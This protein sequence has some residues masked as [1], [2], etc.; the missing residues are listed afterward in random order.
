[1][2]K[3]EDP[4]WPKNNNQSSGLNGQ[5][6]M[7][8]GEKNNNN[9]GG[10]FRFSVTP[11]NDSLVELTRRSSKL[12]V[13]VDSND[14][15][16]RSQRAGVRFTVSKVE[17]PVL[18]SPKTS[19]SHHNKCDENIDDGDIERENYDCKS[20]F[21]VPT[22]NERLLNPPKIIIQDFNDHI[23]E[24]GEQEDS[25]NDSLFRFSALPPF[26][27]PDFDFSERRSISMPCP[28]IPP[29][30]VWKHRRKVWTRNIAFLDCVFSCFPLRCRTRKVSNTPVHHVWLPVFF[31]A[32]SK[33]CV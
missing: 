2:L 9:N 25:E 5:K 28:E 29:M 12:D 33:E 14:E 6:D 15:I 7:K 13:P 21:I 22:N 31:S 20:P 11:V 24:G 18:K 16:D 32:L 19:I 10:T 3:M 27:R 30:D 1:M 17:E 26:R 23:T 4:L 8:N